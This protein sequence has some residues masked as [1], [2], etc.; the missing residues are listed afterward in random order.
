[1]VGLVITQFDSKP[2]RK[3]KVYTTKRS[4]DITVLKTHSIILIRTENVLNRLRLISKEQIK[5]E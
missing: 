2:K 1:M 3:N 5:F 4:I